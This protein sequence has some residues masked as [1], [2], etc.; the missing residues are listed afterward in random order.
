[1]GVAFDGLLAERQPGAGPPGTLL[2]NIK[3]A[4]CEIPSGSFAEVPTL[5]LNVGRRW[6]T[7][8]LQRLEKETT[9]LC[10]AARNLR[11]AISMKIRTP[12]TKADTLWPAPGL[13]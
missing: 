7:D 1:M 13:Y 11:G 6:N 8:E 12:A 10:M 3:S 9:L 4:A 5:G 2:E